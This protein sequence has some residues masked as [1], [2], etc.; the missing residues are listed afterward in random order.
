MPP[1]PPA[2]NET[3]IKQMCCH[4]G[5]RRP[6]LNMLV[7]WRAVAGIKEPW[8]RPGSFLWSQHAE[9]SDWMHYGLKRSAG[10]RPNQHSKSSIKY[11]QLQLFSWQIA[12]GLSCT[13][14]LIWWG[15]TL[16][17]AS[18][19]CASNLDTLKGTEQVC[20]MLTHLR[21]WAAV[22]KIS[23]EQ[24]IFFS[25]SSQFQCCQKLFLVYS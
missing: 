11:I 22:T 5:A 9:Q 25:L 7:R 14:P 13:I 15:C 6:L 16:L 10:A 1:P 19:N 17:N 12:L 8:I 2:I 20:I 23:L 18:N 3:F 4:A 21:R 24:G